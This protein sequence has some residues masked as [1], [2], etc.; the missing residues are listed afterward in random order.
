MLLPVGLAVPGG[1]EGRS[2]EA[3]E[4]EDEKDDDEEEDELLIP[5]PA[6]RGGGGVIATRRGLTEERLWGEGG[7]ETRT[8]E[9]DVG[10]GGGKLEG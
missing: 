6:E 4:G 3:D 7:V 2:I 8:E 9:K 5:A 10:A 1:E